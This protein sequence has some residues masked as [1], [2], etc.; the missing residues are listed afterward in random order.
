MQL[1]I[2]RATEADLETI[3]QFNRRLAEDSGDKLPDFDVLRRGV[4]RAL[5]TPELCAYYVAEHEGQVG[6]QAMVTYELSDWRDGVV[7]WF[8]SVFVLPEWRRRGVFGALYRHIAEEARRDEDAR[9]L[10]LYVIDGN[11]RAKR[12]YERAGMRQS[13]YV[14]YEAE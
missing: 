11:D 3:A 7:W 8:Q 2:R 1:L 9:G 14:V 6:G 4:A 13:P 12:A 10:R 5:R